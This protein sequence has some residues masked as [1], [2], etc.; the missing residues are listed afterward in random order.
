MKVEDK[1]VIKAPD[2]HNVIKENHASNE[3]LSPRIHN[4]PK[5]NIDGVNDNNDNI[6]TQLHKVRKNTPNKLIIA[7]L[8]VNSLPNKFEQL[9]VLVEGK[10]DILVIMETKLD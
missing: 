7:N 6:L 1:S 8:N 2:N 10:V 3:Q 9:K 5:R 4:I